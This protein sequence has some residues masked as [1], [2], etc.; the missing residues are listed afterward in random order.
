MKQFFYRSRQT[1]VGAV[2]LALFMLLIIP[3]IARAKLKSAIGGMFLPAI[4]VSSVGHNALGGML[5]EKSLPPVEGKTHSQ[6]LNADLKLENNQLRA[7]NLRLREAAQWGQ[8]VPWRTKL[9]Q[10]IGRD[11]FNWWRRVKLNLGSQHGIRPNLP[12]VS[13]EGDLVGRISEVG[14]KTSW[15][16]LLGDPNCRFSALIKSSRQQGGIV[17]PRRFN[18]NYRIVELTYLPNDIEVRPGYVVVTSGLGGV[19]PKEIPVGK[20]EDSWLSRNGLYLEAKI[21]I[22]A[23]LNRLEEVRILTEY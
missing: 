17:S 5:S 13:I 23:D 9:A 7:E 19:F 6:G 21:K 12:I 15:A 8:R 16:V 18:P 2:L 1:A 11:S 3:E 4:G 22:H 14:L 10:V 20:V